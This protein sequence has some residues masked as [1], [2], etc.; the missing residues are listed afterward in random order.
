[1]QTQESVHLHRILTMP[2][3]TLQYYICPAVIEGEQFLFVDTAGFGASDMEEI[4]NLK[5]IIGCLSTLGPF[6]KIAGLMFVYGK[7][8]NRL[9]D[10]DP[11]LI[12]WV[13][14][15]PQF[16]KNITVVTTQWDV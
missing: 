10:L 5:D 4:P 9:T 14:C 15:G 1:M 11:K 16:Y 8:D 12:Q 13:Q 7:V 3:G 2:T 6:V